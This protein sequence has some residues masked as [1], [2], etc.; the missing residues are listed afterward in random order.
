MNPRRT[1]IDEKKK[2]KKKM[3][4]RWKKTIGGI[5]NGIHIPMTNPRDLFMDMEA[6]GYFLQENNNSTNTEM[7][8]IFFRLLKAV[9]F[10][11]KIIRVISQ[12]LAC[13]Q[14]L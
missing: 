4:Q 14:I 8:F 12:R 11:E 13:Y 3:K 7:R 5:A 2:K 10:Y 9:P 1:E 6:D